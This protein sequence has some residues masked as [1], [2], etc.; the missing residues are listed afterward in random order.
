MENPPTTSPDHPSPGPPGLT[1]AQEDLMLLL[2]QVE[3]IHLEQ[4]LQLL[5]ADVVEDLLRDGRGWDTPGRKGTPPDR[6]PPH[7]TNPPIPTWMSMSRR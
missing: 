4:R 5:P 7:A 2:L 1:E 6:D 3:L